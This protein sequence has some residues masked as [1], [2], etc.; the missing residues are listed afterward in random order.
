MSQSC[1]KGT[2][3]TVFPLQYLYKATVNEDKEEFV[4]QSCVLCS[5]AIVYCSLVPLSNDRVTQLTPVLDVHLFFLV[6]Q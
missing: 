2:A 1:C 6:L 5:S 3:T 4:R